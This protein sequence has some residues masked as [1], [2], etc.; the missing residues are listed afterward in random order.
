MYWNL[1]VVQTSIPS[2]HF[3]KRVLAALH[4]RFVL[5]LD[6]ARGD[7]LLILIFLFCLVHSFAYEKDTGCK[8][9]LEDVFENEER[10]PG[11]NWNPSS[12]N[13][14]DIVSGQAQV[15]RIYEFL[16]KAPFIY[17]LYDTRTNLRQFCFPSL[18]SRSSIYLPGTL[19]FFQIQYGARPIGT[20]RSVSKIHFTPASQVEF[21]AM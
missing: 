17:Y 9:F 7:K 15:Y 5:C 10:F 1:E 18:P 8:N 20:M 12:V 16:S 4:V 14:T 11:G 19:S 21:D 2:S 6:G 13:W 3:E